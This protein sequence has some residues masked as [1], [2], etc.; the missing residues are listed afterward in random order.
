MKITKKFVSY[1]LVFLMAFSSFTILPSEFW[2]LADVSAVNSTTEESNALTTKNVDQLTTEKTTKFLTE[3]TT[4]SL[5]EISKDTSSD[6]YVVGDFEYKLINNNT[7][8]E[9]TTYNGTSTDIVI[10]DVIS[11]SEIDNLE[12]KPVTSIANGVFKQKGLTSVV[13]GVNIVTIGDNAFYS[14]NI[15]ALDLSKCVNLVSIGAGAFGYNK[16][17]AQLQLPSNL[18]II[19][20]NA[21]EQCRMIE[22][23][24]INDNITNIGSNAFAYC[25][26]LKSISINGG[27]NA[28]MG[29]KSF[30]YCSSLESVTIGDGVIEIGKYSFS[31]CDALTKAEIAGTVTTIGE[32]AFKNCYKLNQ[33]ILKNG[34]KTIDRQAFYECRSL[35]QI[36][37]PDTV[38]TINEYAFA[39]CKILKTV[40]MG[41]STAVLIRNVFNN[42]SLLECFTASTDSTAYTSDNGVLLNK[43]KT[44]LVYYPRARV[45]G[46]TI[47]N[48]VTEIKEYTFSHCSQ[49]TEINIGQGVK[50]IN[51]YAFE[52]CTAL[53]KVTIGNNVE[54]IKK[55]AFYYCDSIEELNIPNSVKTLEQGSV[56]NCETLK[57]VTIGSG[58]ITLDGA[59]TSNNMIESYT[60]S[61]DNP[62]YMSVD[63]VLFN[64]NQTDI[65]FYP[66]AKAGAYTIPNTVTE[67]RNNLFSYCENLTAITIGKGVKT[68]GRYA[69]SHC[70][71]LKNV[72]IGENVEK[73]MYSAFEWCPSLE[74]IE[75]PNNIKSIEG[76][77]F[78]MGKL[79]YITIGS[80]CTSINNGALGSK[81]VSITVSK[82]NPTYCSENGILYNK[83]KTEIIIYPPYKE[84]AYV[85]PN[86]VKAIKWN[87]FS[88]AN[89]LTELTIG[90]QITAIPNSA[91]SGCSKLKKLYLGKGI[92]TIGENIFFGKTSIKELDLSNCVNLI[93][94]AKDAMYEITSLETVIL[95]DNLE[96]IGDNA[97]YGCSKLKKVKFGSKLQN[98]GVG[99]FQYCTSL[100]SLTITDGNNTI[101]GG[102]A[103]NS[104][105]ALK[106]ITFNGVKEISAVA[107]SKCI[108][109][110]KFIVNDDT[111]TEIGMMAFENC[112]ALEEVDLGN[113]L[114]NTQQCVFKGCSNLKKVSLGNKLNRVYFS[115]FENCSSL[116]EITIPA[117][118]TYIDSYAF[119]GC[120]SLTAVKLLGKETTIRYK[121]CIPN[122]DLCVI[123]CH[124]N[125]T[126]HKSLKDKGF[127]NVRFL[128]DLLIPEDITINGVS[129]NG[130]KSEIK[131]YTIYVNEITNVDIV[132]VFKQDNV[133]YKV[134]AEN[135]VYSI[136]I[137]D[138][139]N[140]IVYTYKI[141]VKE[142]A[143]EVKYTVI[144]DVTLTLNNINDTKV[145]GSIALPAGTYKLK[146]AK[147]QQ[148]LGYNK[149]VADYCDSLTLREKYLS[150]ITLNA[151]GGT[152]TFQFDTATKKLIIKHDSYLPNEYLIGDLNTILKPVGDRPLSIGTQQ[153]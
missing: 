141:T 16:A 28:I 19:G 32:Y 129:I 110:E 34:L 84:G 18:K 145:S 21:F 69:F 88:S 126:T 47:P 45:G 27:N 140:T 65:V 122:N 104:C 136:N 31:N 97:F 55:F 152:Y 67:I 150:Y 48:T 43:D 143:P 93:S 133:N 74:K 146:I 14:N 101:I 91:F 111:L 112:S 26:N 1:I 115:L 5:I 125:S 113:G 9:I 64:K 39:N 22:V 54:S 35:E 82:D 7:E 37:I 41:K 10:P 124:K 30:F 70:T 89:E 79:K 127:T 11:N 23:L 147:D 119:D 76:S 120:T 98:I 83:D 50:T 75:I 95:P 6:T 78:S 100:E 49:L 60:V 44:E 56:N 114:E 40:N 90:D 3:K 29:E 57:T 94:I 102:N 151:T 106:S 17:M 2:G 148:Q 52:F 46:Y 24:E 109:L 25:I 51:Q 13:L 68:I 118:V 123:Y 139:Y 108:S 12:G 42:A 92:K 121:N 72:T 107:F 71:N 81:L 130:F 138:G 87:T 85:L 144:G 15:S 36:N 149:T 105:K 153:L 80:G 4:K 59:F 132:P 134:T 33:L 8:L 63:G 61:N 135:N 99:A 117:T 103:F 53:K 38:T 66:R 128:E 77:C 62:A 58:C 73:I 142:K 137:F 96:S 116:Q 20:N 86:T 131:E